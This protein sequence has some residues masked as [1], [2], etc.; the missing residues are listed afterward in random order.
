MLELPC[1]HYFHE[2]CIMPW[3][4]E[5]RAWACYMCALKSMCALRMWLH[6]PLHG[7][8]AWHVCIMCVEHASL[9]SCLLHA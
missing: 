8:S 1:C 3:L 5:V 4:Q 2:D 6:V 7:T 9:Y